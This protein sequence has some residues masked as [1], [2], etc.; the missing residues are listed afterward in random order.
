V[1]QRVPNAG[2]TNREPLWYYVY[3]LPMALGPVALLLPAAWVGARAAWRRDRALGAFLAAWAVGTIALLSVSS[4]K[5]LRYLLVALPA[6]AAWI[7]LGIAERAASPRLAAYLRGLATA[8][9]VGLPALAALL[10]VAG[11]VLFPAGRAHAVAGALLLLGAWLA[12]RI[13]T[14]IASRGAAQRGAAGS[15]VPAALVLCAL[16]LG[17]RAVASAYLLERKSDEPLEEIGAVA[18]RY[19]APGEPLLVSGRYSASLHFALDRP[20]IAAEDE[21]ALA[22]ALAR[23]ASPLLLVKKRALPADLAAGWEELGAWGDPP[24][25]LYRRR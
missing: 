12:I 22:A 9:A 2:R 13:A 18:A 14:R 6:W 25:R 24:L 20:L 3:A 7:G 11:W 19:L 1:L 10:G 5:E 23:G 8:A 17:L 21:A 15:A 4:G 16:I